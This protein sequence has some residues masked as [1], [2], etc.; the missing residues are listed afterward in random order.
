MATGE[1]IE[2]LVRESVQ[3]LAT[4][5]LCQVFSDLIPGYHIRL[6]TEQ[7]QAQ[8]V[9][10]CHRIR[11]GRGGCGEREVHIRILRSLA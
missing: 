10:W 11:G 7:E 8:K 2:P 3:K 9:S 5:S 1:Q 4:V 6:P